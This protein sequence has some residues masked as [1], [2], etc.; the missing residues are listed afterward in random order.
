MIYRPPGRPS[1]F[2]KWLVREFILELIES[3]LAAFL[4]SWACLASFGKRV[5]F[6][7]IIGIIAAITTNM[8]YWNWYGF[9]K[10]YTMGYMT[11]Q[12]IGFV[13]AGLAIAFVLK[14]TPPRIVA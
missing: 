4:L 1:A 11:T 10:L 12:F 3:T 5:V 7:A 13:C 8:S 14:N 9:P 6:V 2:G